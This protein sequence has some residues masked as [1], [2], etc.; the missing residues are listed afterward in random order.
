MIPMRNRAE[1]SVLRFPHVKD[2]SHG[3][4]G[5]QARYGEVLA[6]A[7]PL[8]MRHE[9]GLASGQTIFFNAACIK[10]YF[11]MLAIDCVLVY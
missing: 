1:L 9:A 7:L 4:E 2:L 6:N 11:I 8:W 10:G 3:T 5:C